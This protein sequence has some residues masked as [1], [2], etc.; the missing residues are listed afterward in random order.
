[1][2]ESDFLLGEGEV[3]KASY[4]TLGE[5]VKGGINYFGA[6]FNTIPDPNETSGLKNE[7]S[8]L[9]DGNGYTYQIDLSSRQVEKQQSGAHNLLL[10]SIEDESEYNFD[11]TYS[12]PSWWVQKFNLEGAGPVALPDGLI[13]LKN[14]K[15][16]EIYLTAEYAASDI[17]TLYIRGANLCLED[18]HRLILVGTDITTSIDDLRN[19]MFNHRHDGSFGEPFIRIQDLIGKYV[20]GEFGPSSIPG[21]EFPMYL[22]RKGYQVDDNARNGNNAMLG[23]LFM[24]SPLFS[25]TGEIESRLNSRRI[26]FGNENASI[27]MSLSYLV[28]SND[29]EE[30]G[31]IIVRSTLNNEILSGIN[32][33]TADQNI[34]NQTDLVSDSKNN[35]KINNTRMRLTCRLIIKM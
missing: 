26:V 3:L 21:N 5:A 6:S 34:F 29:D 17:H 33:L 16:N 28:L 8:F 4:V 20:T 35:T 18:D 27:G 12:L 14:L 11:K 24:G 19:K 2:L 9:A 13:Y 1:M 23:D 7:I 32:T 10:S 25:S 30:A 15:T 22:H 31:R